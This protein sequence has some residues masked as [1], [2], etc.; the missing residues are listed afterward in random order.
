MASSDL[1]CVLL[2]WPLY[3]T[4]GMIKPA[5]GSLI[6]NSAFATICCSEFIHDRCRMCGQIYCNC[7]STKGLKHISK[8]SHILSAYKLV[9]TRDFPSTVPVLYENR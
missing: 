1:V 9:V 3:A 2:N 8:A 4:E 5:G 7:V 6:T